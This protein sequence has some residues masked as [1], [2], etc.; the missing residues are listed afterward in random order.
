MIRVPLLLAVLALTATQAAAGS[1]TVM[2]GPNPLAPPAPVVPNPQG[3]APAPTP[4]QDLSAPRTQV[5]RQKGQ[6]EISASLG[7]K[8]RALRP[9]DG[10]SPGSSFNEDLQRRNRSATNFAPTINLTMPVE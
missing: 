10:F 4:N 8:Q 3:F 7:E 5:K 1:F 2:S 6:A 9:G